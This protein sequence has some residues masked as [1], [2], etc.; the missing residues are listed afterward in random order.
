M[1][2]LRTH[3]VYSIRGQIKKEI[4]VFNIKG[5]AL[6]DS[7]LSFPLSESLPPFFFSVS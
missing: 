7:S 6:G 1:Y 2:R 4:F 3:H 5:L